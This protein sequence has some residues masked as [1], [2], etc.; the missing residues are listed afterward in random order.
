MLGAC[1]FI[2]CI[3]SPMHSLFFNSTTQNLNG[4]VASNTLTSANI[5]K[6]GKSCSVSGAIVKLFF[7]GAGNSIEEAAKHGGITKIA[8][9]DRESFSVLG[10][11]Y[12]KEC[13]I[14]WGE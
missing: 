8:V 11:L 4:E 6:S 13:V 1:F 7:Y 5:L 14:V 10:D 2:S 9:I 12:Y 3:S